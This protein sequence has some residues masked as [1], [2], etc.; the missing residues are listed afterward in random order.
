MKYSHFIVL[1]FCVFTLSYVC[2]VF[3]VHAE[4]SYDLGIDIET[5]F[6]DN[7]AFMP[8]YNDS[9]AEAY[10]IGF[11]PWINLQW[12]KKKS[13]FR[14]TAEY[15]SEFYMDNK[16]L[17]D[18]DSVKVKTW[19][20]YSFTDRFLFVYS[21]FLNVSGFG[22]EYIDRPESRDDYIEYSTLSGFLYNFNSHIS[23]QV[24][25]IWGFMKF[26]DAISEQNSTLHG[27][28]WKDIGFIIHGKYE[29]F[30][31]MM[32]IYG[33]T[34]LDREYEEYEPVPGLYQIN[35]HFGFKTILPMKTEIMLKA[36]LFRYEFNGV[37]PRHTESDYNNYGVI[38]SVTQPF[39][40][41][42]FVELD[43]YSVYKL[44]DRDVRLFYRNAGV[45]AKARWDLNDLTNMHI[46]FKFDE[47]DYQGL[48]DG[49][50]E[51]VIQ[52]GV[53]VGY[54]ILNW[55]DITTAYRYFNKDSSNP[56]LDI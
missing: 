23:L 38:V 28:D 21:D 8:D 9:D 56:D 46:W 2:P 22:E 34:L 7:A 48:E 6:D 15:I 5:A 32:F 44:S 20:N 19:W 35:A 53:K 33:Y 17:D 25:A 16:E 12:I 3:I 4:F 24:D 36:K 50:E 18:H 26:D 31:E 11:R 29:V 49:F 27:Q 10:V 55:M 14:L 45:S 51:T 13:D 52:T 1:L 30:P 47:L 42:G 43:G 39:G 41:K 54:S 40:T 37:P